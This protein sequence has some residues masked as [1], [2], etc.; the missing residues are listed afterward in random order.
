[1]NEIIMWRLAT[2][3]SFSPP[4]PLTAVSEPGTGAGL[5]VLGLGTDKGAGISFINFTCNNLWSA[6]YMDTNASL[7]DLGT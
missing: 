4:L 3:P 7:N 6:L 5:G 1:M 2:K